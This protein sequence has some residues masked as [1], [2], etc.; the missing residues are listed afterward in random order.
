[1]SD[2][3]DELIKEIAEK[4][5]IVVGRDDPIL[6]LKTINARLMQDSAK[7]QQ[8]M[9]DKFKAEME[10]ITQRW[11]KDSK[12]KAERVLN[13]ALTASKEVMGN[14]LQE[15]V[16]VIANSIRKEIDL[17][18]IQQVREPVKK[19]KKIALFNIVASTLTLVTVCIAIWITFLR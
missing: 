18:L 16:S 7:A 19:G 6:I 1:M 13:A 11:E 9:L 17:A 10:E 2:S 4:H 15:S 8:E 3:V 5:K 14:L 12:E